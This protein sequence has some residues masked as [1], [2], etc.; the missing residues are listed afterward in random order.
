LFDVS[1]G[2]NNNDGKLE[3]PDRKLEGIY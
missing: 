2:N 1:N 3:F